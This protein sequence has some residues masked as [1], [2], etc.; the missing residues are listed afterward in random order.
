MSFL[1]LCACAVLFAALALI[2]R[3]A[4]AKG[5]PL[6]TLT[7]GLAFLFYAFT[8]YRE[9]INALRELAEGAGLSTSFS[10]L[11]KMLAVA[12]LAHI[13]AEL[14]RDMGEGTI[15]SRIEL[16]GR[17]EIL[18]LALPLFIELC[19]LAREVLS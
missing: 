11:F 5:A 9:P 1:S 12:C 16:C 6:V 17:I 10:S 8:R 4:G 7:G 3:D 14:C 19:T 18:L 15:A 13:A 2:L